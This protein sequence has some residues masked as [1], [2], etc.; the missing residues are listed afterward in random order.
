VRAGLSAETRR[1][2]PAGLIAA[3]W[4]RLRFTDELD[5]AALESFVR[6]AQAAGFLKNAIPLDRMFSRAP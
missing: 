6:D 4:P 1:E 5:A 2:M 3:A